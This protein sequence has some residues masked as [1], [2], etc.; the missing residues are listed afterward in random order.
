MEEYSIRQAGLEDIPTIRNLADITFRATYASIITPGQIEYMMDWMYSDAKLREE[1]SSGVTYLL[2]EVKGRSVGYVSFS[3]QSP[4]LYH[5]HKI[6][7]LPHCQGK[8]YGRVLFRAAEARMR[9]L[10][11]K[12]FELN[13]NRHNKAL[14]FYRH[15][16]M[17][18]ARSGDFDIG[19][20]FYMNDY[21][22]RKD[23]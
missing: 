3:E 23:L 13:V 4:A 20:G 11:A 8:G 21:I 17:S 2:L 19:G 15:E 14:D 5:L 9:E 1:L 6:Y 10:G 16:G 22:M 18:I 12:A 7:F